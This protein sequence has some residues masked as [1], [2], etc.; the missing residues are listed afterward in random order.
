MQQ[1]QAQ[2]RVVRLTERDA[3]AD[4]E[5]LLEHFR[6]PPR[7]AGV[8]FENFVPNPQFPSQSEARSRLE[9]L[10]S[11]SREKPGFALFKRKEPRPSVYLDGGF[12]VG[13]THLLAA[14]WH[15]FSGARFFLSFAEL[16]FIIGALG[17][18]RA[19]DAFSGAKLLCI[20]EFEL[21]D[22]GNTLVVSRFLGKL[23]PKGVSVVTTSNTLPDQLGEGRFNADDFRREI[24]GI[25]AHFEAIR[26]DGPDYRHREGLPAPHPLEPGR[27]LEAFERYSGVKAFEGFDALLAHLA[28]LHPI[29]FAGLLEGVQAVFLE[30]LAPIQKQDDALRF[31]HFVDK[32]YDREVRLCASGCELGTIFPESYRHNGYA[33]KYARCLSRLGELLRESAN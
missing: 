17:M 20:D 33:K 3:P 9:R 10:V 5:E 14:T 19:V 16:T 11:E 32:L 12:G 30:G 2:G 7:F 1:Q 26:I 23:I 21:D 4:P 6:P 25:A 8:R 15:A 31:V 27:L 22:V 24:Q 29:R 28:R 13:K 18:A